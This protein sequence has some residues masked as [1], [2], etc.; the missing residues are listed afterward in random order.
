MMFVW[1][2]LS[3]AK[4]E[5]AWEERFHGPLQTGLAITRLPGGKSI[6]VEVYC[7]RRTEAARI[8]KEFGGQ[9]RILKNQNWAA[10]SAESLRPVMIRDSLIVAHTREIAEQMRASRPTRRVLFIPGEMAF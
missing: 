10:K 4:W 3:G 6:R 7:A 2:K 8:Q 9:I 1:S 5:D